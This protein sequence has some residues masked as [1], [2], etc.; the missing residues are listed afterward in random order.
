MASTQLG[1]GTMAGSLG[2]QLSISF[3]LFDFYFEKIQHFW[4]SLSRLK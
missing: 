3:Y 1:R 2:G 4:A